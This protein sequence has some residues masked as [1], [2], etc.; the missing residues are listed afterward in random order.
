MARSSLL[1]VVLLFTVSG[2]VQAQ[3]EE[4]KQPPP[5]VAEIL[6]GTPEE[7]IKRYDKNGDGALSKDE[8]PPFLVQ[9]FERAD[10][11]SNGKLDRAEVT[12]MFQRMRAFFA[13]GA[14]GGMDIERIVD[15]ILQQQD[16]DKDGKI[17][18]AE[19]KGR[20]AEA[21]EKVDTNKDGFLDRAEL[22]VL[23]QRIGPGPGGVQGP[24]AD[25][26]ALDKNADGRLTREEL[27]G[28]PF[29]ARF[30]EIDTDRSGMID[31]REFEK[32]QKAQ[33]SK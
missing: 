13:Q 11:D 9:N 32:Y 1:A 3:K 12:A 24:G 14:P 21:F 27:R 23:A 4:K 25:F 5:P 2:V 31:R 6:K 26:D 7:F 28:T 29:F 22:R 8:L 19:A 16:T 17:S 10:S 15:N 33:A 18:R 30:D 20:L